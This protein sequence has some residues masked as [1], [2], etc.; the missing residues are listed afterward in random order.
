MALAEKTI[1]DK[2]EILENGIIQV[3]RADI[4]ERD[5]I[6]IARTYH[7]WTLTPGQDISDQETRVQ[8]IANTVWTQE[9]VSAYLASLPKF[10]E[11]SEPSV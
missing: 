5:G 3:R 9:V 1:I 2:I 10:I 4:V 7:R 8:D 6:E 11:T